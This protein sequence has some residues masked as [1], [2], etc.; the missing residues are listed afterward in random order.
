M[1]RR[2][3]RSSQESGKTREARSADA[4]TTS[5][6]R[7]VE[8]RWTQHGKDR[9]YVKTADGVDLGYADLVA[10]TVVP[11]DPQFESSLH[12]CLLR[13]MPHPRRVFALANAGDI[14]AEPDDRDDQDRHRPARRR[15]LL[16]RVPNP[17]SSDDDWQTITNGRHKV[18]RRLDSLGHGWRVLHSADL[19][20]RDEVDHLVIGPA[21]VYTVTSRCH[22][23]RDIVVSARSLTVDGHRTGYLSDARD[24]ARQVSQVLTEACGW[25]V[26]T[27]ALIVLAEV[28]SFTVR[29][30]PSEVNVVTS[31]HVTDWLRLQQVRLAPTAV[32][33]VFRVSRQR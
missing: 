20:F 2:V 32:D 17:T 15:S 29:Q 5:M 33:Q 28:G 25:T 18:G 4:D 22:P 11:T 12:D 27:R 23:G 9:V 30:T 26:E 21:G 24:E 8:T 14:G 10:R 7:L 1:P 13:W 6:I 31:Q 19:G 16:N 3:I